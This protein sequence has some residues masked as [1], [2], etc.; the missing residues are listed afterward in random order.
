MGTEEMSLNIGLWHSIFTEK[1]NMHW[2]SIKFGSLYHHL[3]KTAGPWL[4]KIS[5]KTLCQEI[6][7]SFMTMMSKPR[8]NHG[9]ETKMKSEKIKNKIGKRWT[10]ECK[11][12][13]TEFMK[14]F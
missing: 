14:R 3:S 13:H 6:R 11:E 7:F 10:E 9:W 1:F 5:V 12:Q 2:I 8:W 4:M